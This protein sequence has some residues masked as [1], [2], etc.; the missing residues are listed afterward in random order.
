MEGAFDKIESAARMV[1][2]A[3]SE[4]DMLRSQMAILRRLCKHEPFDT[5]ALRQTI[6]QRVIENGKYILI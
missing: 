2:A 5:I 4:G 6:A 3:S 1:I